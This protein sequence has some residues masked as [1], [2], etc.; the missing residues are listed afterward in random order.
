[1]WYNS[2]SHSQWRKS[3]YGKR[4]EALLSNRNILLGGVSILNIDMGYFAACGVI[5]CG[6][7]F[8][9]GKQRENEKRY[10]K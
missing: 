7:L 6:V 3:D 5:V 4:A 1:M 10:N 8:G 9:I 2:E